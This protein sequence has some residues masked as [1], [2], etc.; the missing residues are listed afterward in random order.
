MKVKAAI[1]NNGLEFISEL[2]EKPMPISLAAKFLRL[3]DDLTKENMFIEKQRVGIIEKYGNKDE[4]GELIV[5]EG[6]VTFEHDMAQKAQEELN[7]LANLEIDI[8]DRN[9][10]EEEL[11]K[12]DLQLSMSQFAILRNFLHI[13][14]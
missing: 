13:D 10:T 12:A 3:A 14:E 8:K 9:I 11:E 6:N 4:K 1:I 5:N 7:E 2:S